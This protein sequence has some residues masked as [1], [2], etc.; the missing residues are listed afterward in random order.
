MRVPFR[1]TDARFKTEILCERDRG[2]ADSEPLRCCRL[3]RESYTVESVRQLAFERSATSARYSM[4]VALH[5]TTAL[6]RAFSS[7]TEG[8]SA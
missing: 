1:E 2:N 8:F 3:G 6:L 4:P 5:D 7:V